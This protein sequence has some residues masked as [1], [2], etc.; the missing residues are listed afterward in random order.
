MTVS[1]TTIENKQIA[2]L[3]P[4]D[5]THGQHLLVAVECTRSARV[6]IAGCSSAG[7]GPSILCTHLL[8]RT[9][10]TLKMKHYCKERCSY[11]R[12]ESHKYN[13]VRAV[14]YRLHCGADPS[15]RLKDQNNDR[16]IQT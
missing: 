16:S 15:R 1:C 5:D 12:M 10:E 8:E 4:V 3:V 11:Y 7:P 13:I 6:F 9:T 2:Y 14:K